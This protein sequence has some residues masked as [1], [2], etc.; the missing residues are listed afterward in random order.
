MTLENKIYEIIDAPLQHMGFGIVRTRIYNRNVGANNVKVL[1][2]LLERLDEVPITVG[3]CTNASNHISTLL[4]V[5][6]VI[7]SKYTLEVA[8]AGIERPLIKLQDFERFKDRVA[9]IKLHNLVEGSKRHQGTLMGVNGNNI[10]VKIESKEIIEIDFENIK[11]A[12][13]VLTDELFRKIIK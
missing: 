8:S 13:L 5:E 1:E 7:E 12:R 10:K 3:D 9:D 2:I 4:D 6:D 11:G